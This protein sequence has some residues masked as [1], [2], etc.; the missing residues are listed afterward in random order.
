[1]KSRPPSPRS[2]ARALRAVVDTNVWVS[3]LIAPEGAPRQVIEALRTGRIECVV[4]WAL[5][6]EIVDV[7]RRPRLHRLGVTEDDVQAVLTILGPLLPDVDVDVPIRDPND[8][9]VVSA[10]LAGR[11]DAIITGDQDLID[12]EALV[13]WLRE[14]G[15]AV[16]SPAT[17]LAALSR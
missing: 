13:T 11:A 17:A 16:L 15:V 10:A 6:E 9:R 4:S 7:L 2:G 5:A 14:R 3:G 1:M 12:D 8:A